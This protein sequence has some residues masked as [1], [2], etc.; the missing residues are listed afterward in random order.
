MYRSQV[1]LRVI[2]SPLVWP[3]PTASTVPE[4]LRERAR[5]HCISML[6]YKLVE[7]VLKPRQKHRAKGLK[8]SRLVKEDHN[9]WDQNTPYPMLDHLRTYLLSIH[10]LC[11]K[12]EDNIDDRLYRRSTRT[13]L[14]SRI[15]HTRSLKK[16][17]RKRGINYWSRNARK[18]AVRH[19]LP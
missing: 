15:R 5:Q 12:W 17:L 1:P 7:L 14:I 11:Q 8:E 6:Y 19:H 2:Y 3:L 9:R 18:W 13:S 4:F 16:V 10:L